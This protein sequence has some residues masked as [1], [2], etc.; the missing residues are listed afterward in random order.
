M[1]LGERLQHAW[2]AFTNNEPYIAYR[3]IGVGSSGRPDRPRPPR[4]SEKTIV[5]SIINKMST[6]AASI[7]IEHIKLDDQDR[8]IE[9]I[10][11][12]SLNNCLTIEANIDQTGRAFRQDMFQTLFEKG[13]VAVVPVD[14]TISPKISEAYKINTM[15]V[16][17]IT[18]WFPLHVKVNLYNEKTGHKEDILL[19]KKQVAIVEN[20][21]FSVMNSP[22]STLQRLIRKL[23]LLDDVDEQSGSGKLDMIIQLPYV[24][25]TDA[26]RQQAEERRKAIETQL[27]DSKYGIAYTDGTEHITQLNRSVDNNLLKQVE[28]LTEQLYSQLGITKEIMDGTANEETMNNYYT[29]IIEP[30]VAATVDEMKRKFLTKTARSQRQTIDFFRDP[31]KLVTVSNL[32]EVSDKFTRNEILTSNEVRQIIGIKPASDPSAD[33]LRNKNIAPSAYEQ[34]EDGYY[35]EPIV[36]SPMDLP[37]NTL[38][39]E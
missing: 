16:G 22:N 20:P 5:T 3:D 18:E 9:V 6:D 37:V 33:T 2:N 38:M 14:T 15:R 13:V 31:F 34:T 7:K 29:R 17:T 4:G 26:R 11:E 21:F 36:E 1:G 24:I 32:A 35:D 10:A 28:Y 19:P 23:A 39:E 8:F 25:K 12:S 30:V 27:K